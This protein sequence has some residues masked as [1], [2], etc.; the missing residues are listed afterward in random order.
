MT[1]KQYLKLKGE[2]QV[3]LMQFKRKALDDKVNVL[4]EDYK[5]LETKIIQAFF[6]QRGFSVQ[7]YLG[8]KETIRQKKIAKET[9]ANEKIEGVGKEIATIKEDSDKKGKEITKKLSKKDQEIFDIKKSMKDLTQD[10]FEML[11]ENT[12]RVDTL[13]EVSKED[14]IFLNSKVKDLEAKLEDAKKEVKKEVKKKIDKPKREEPKKE[15][16]TK[17]ELKKIKEIIKDDP[18]YVGKLA[19]LI[20]KRG[21]IPDEGYN[22]SYFNK[23]AT[24]VYVDD[25]VAG[26]DFWDRDGT[27][28]EPNYANDSMDMGSGNITTTGT[29]TVG[30]LTDGTFSV[31]GGAITGAT[32]NISLWTNDSAYIDLTDLS[33][34]A[35]GLTYTNTT[36]VLSLTA[37]YVVPTTTQETNWGTAYTNR[38]TSATSPLNIT[39][40]VVS[41]SQANTSTSGYLSDTDWDTFNDKQTAMGSDD[42]YVT[43]DEKTVIGNTIRHNLWR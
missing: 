20:G 25:K 41:I 39:S 16:L 23:Y 12:H 5:N 22:D 31:T 30:T 34:T 26:E 4:G 15:L 3:T 14:F 2:L 37:G 24:K 18:Q 6:K 43:D 42:N 32:G 21:M 9:K 33:S 29:V 13:L 11:N 7:E 17:E 38:I 1:S 27:T 19:N 10:T 28:L 35:T 36:G 8:Y 40:N